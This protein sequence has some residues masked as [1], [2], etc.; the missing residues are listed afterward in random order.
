MTTVNTLGGAAEA[1]KDFSLENAHDCKYANFWVAYDALDKS[2]KSLV[3]AGIEIAKEVQKAMVHIGTSVIEK[4][5]VKM[6]SGFRY[7]LLEND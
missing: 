4:K 1:E 7:V 3:D 5:E 2:N 6:G